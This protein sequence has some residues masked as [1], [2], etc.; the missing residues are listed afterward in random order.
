MKSLLTAVL[1][2]LCAGLFS[3]QKEVDDIFKTTAT[4]GNG[5]GTLKRTVLY[6]G[7]DSSV[8][9]Y[10]YNS[11]GKLIAVNSEIDSS[12]IVITNSQTIERDN[13]G[14]IQRIITK[15]SEFSRLGIDSVVADVRSSSG[16]Y[17]NRVWRINFFGLIFG[18]STTFSYDASGKIVSEKDYVDDGMGDIDSTRVDYIFSGS[19]LIAMNG[20]DLSSGNTTPDATYLFEYDSKNSPLVLNNEAFILNN[21]MEW[22]SPNNFKKMT[23]NV[24]GD[25]TT[26]I[27]TWDYIYNSANKPLSA[28]LTEDGQSGIRMNYY[29]N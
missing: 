24:S 26:H 11:G 14:I 21:F 13:Q 25:P 10:F 23:V 8:S 16:K 20:Y 22:Y 2:V 12:G 28:N 17:L 6:Q 27:Q 18:D 3:C 15:A 29:Y 1:I 7:S 19:N 9:N 4:S 5:I